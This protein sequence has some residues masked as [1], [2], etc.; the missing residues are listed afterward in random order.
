MA[1]RVLP[2]SAPR[3]VDHA[4]SLPVAVLGL[5]LAPSA[6]D[7]L[8]AVQPRLEASL[9][10]PLLAVS[11]AATLVLLVTWLRFPR[12]NWL[13]AATLATAAAVA[14]RVVGADQAP[15]LSL[16]SVVALGVGGAFAN[17][18]ISPAGV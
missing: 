12:T 14:L 7:L 13:A 18:E 15:L 5:A 2:H 16:L 8:N 4:A 11:S 3:H 10:M 1:V 9:L 6:L 17:A